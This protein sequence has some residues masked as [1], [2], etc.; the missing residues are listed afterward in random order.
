MKVRPH[1]RRSLQCMN[2]NNSN[3]NNSHNTKHM[4]MAQA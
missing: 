4:I 1:T 3:N 2:Y